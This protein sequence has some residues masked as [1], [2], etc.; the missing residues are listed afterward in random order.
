MRP[1]IRA[2]VTSRLALRWCEQE[3]DRRI[4]GQLRR[5]RPV[6]IEPGHVDVG[7]EVVGVGAPEHEHLD[8]GDQ[9]A[10]DLGAQQVHGRGRDVGEQHGPSR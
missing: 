2:I 1:S 9:I 7:D 10:H 3:G 5:L 6:R 8:Q 4:A